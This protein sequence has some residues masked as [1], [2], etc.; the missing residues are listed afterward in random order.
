VSG[1]RLLAPIAIRCAALGG[2]V[3]LA[4]LP[5]YVFVE[6]PWRPLVARLAVAFVLGVAL[7]QLRSVVADH[8][9]AAHRARVAPPRRPARPARPRTQPG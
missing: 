6:A 3:L 4:A 5:V 2:V 8:V 7:L 9:A 1:D